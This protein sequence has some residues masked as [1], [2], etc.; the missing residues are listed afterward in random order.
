MGI[1]SSQGYNTDRIYVSVLSTIPLQSEIVM[2]MEYIADKHYGKSGPG[3]YI[4]INL[5][6]DVMLSLCALKMTINIQAKC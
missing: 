1:F 5:L 6:T 4:T 2:L 3:K